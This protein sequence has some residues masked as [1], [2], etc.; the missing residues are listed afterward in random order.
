MI[1]AEGPSFYIL[2]LILLLACAM[3]LPLSLASDVQKYYKT[4]GY[5]IMDG[6]PGPA[7]YDNGAGIES[8]SWM[9]TLGL[10]RRL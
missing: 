2:M 3:L 4:L 10:K 9:T 7:Y 6:S 1:M 5:T 8:Y